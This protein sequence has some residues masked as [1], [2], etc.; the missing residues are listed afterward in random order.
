M[1]FRGG[2]SSAVMELVV[3]GSPREVVVYGDDSCT[4]VFGDGSGTRFRRCSGSSVEVLVASTGVFVHVWRGTWH[5]HV[6]GV[7]V[8]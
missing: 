7:P 8:W 2:T 1:R 4:R 5:I 6:L 3:H